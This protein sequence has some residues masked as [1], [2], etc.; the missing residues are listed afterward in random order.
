MPKSDGNSPI[1]GYIVQ[2]ADA[3]DLNFITFGQSDSNTLMSKVS[4]LDKDKEYL[5][6]VLAVNAVGPSEPACY[7]E[8]VLL[9]SGESVTLL[10]C[11][12]R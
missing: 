9:Q 6:R 12:V 1:T 5:V 2:M 7:P 4:S 3:S 10:R 11:F 8:P